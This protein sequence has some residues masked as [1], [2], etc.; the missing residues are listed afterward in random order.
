MQNAVFV[1][2]TN[3]RALAPVR[4]AEARRLLTAEQA[5]VFR[6]YPFTIILK[7]EVN[8]PVDADVQLKLAQKAW[9]TWNG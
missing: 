2:D 5:A 1:L 8:E 3:K 9:R 7:T 6:R 4:P